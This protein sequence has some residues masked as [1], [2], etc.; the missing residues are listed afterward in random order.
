MPW[1]F[2]KKTEEKPKPRKKR[3]FAGG[4]FGRLLNDWIA[5]ST[6][7]DSEISTSLPALRNRARQL[8]RDN[9]F[10]KAA[11]RAVQVNVVGTGME[12]QAQIKMMR[13]GG[14]N[15]DLNEKIEAIWKSWS[16]A[17]NC[18]VSGKLALNE[19]CSMVV[20]SLVDSG[21]ILIRMV[22]KQFGKSR[23]P[24]G[25]EIIEADQLDE[26]R[27]GK[28][29][30]N[31]IRMGVEV[32][33]WHRPVNYW[34]TQTHP[35]DN[36]TGVGGKKE[37]VPIP[38]SQ[39]LHLFVSDRPGQTRGYPMMH[40]SIKRLHH[41]SGF[42]EAE[43]IYNRSA[44]S[45]MGFLETP[46]GEVY[47]DDVVDDERVMDFAPGMIRGLAPG[48]RFVGF[49]PN[50]P[51]GNYEPFVRA[52][53]RAIA[54]GIGCSYETIS[55]DFSQTNYSS[56]RLSLLE[57]RE[58]WKVLQK[59]IIQKFLQPVYEKWLEQAVLSGALQLD[60]YSAMPE[61]YHQVRWQTRG[62]SWVDPLKEVK[63]YQEAVRNGFL[64]V[65]DVVAQTGG[66]IEDLIRA[67]ERELKLMEESGLT[68][69][70][71]PAQV[72]SVSQRW[73]DDLIKR[74]LSEDD[75]EIQGRRNQSDTD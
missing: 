41:L 37:S 49:N 12:L 72:G 29:N 7:I 30:G 6:N 65:T 17:G 51:S 43:V 26:T 61:H 13:G 34:I 58:N 20:G 31:T 47:S 28:H 18:H 56:S 2:K 38:A 50:K 22:P 21:E 11:K 16:Q 60:G 8:V 62:W 45:M 19:I 66:D 1:P 40:S 36:V 54:A 44:A 27:N 48:E 15:D 52:M 3:N 33:E 57:D 75:G 32:D 39:I 35:G 24:L 68:Y 5:A 69:D 9:D 4:Q 70:S 10:A 14:M 55:R 64:T 73:E 25:L 74:A 71:N 63:A 42:E 46:E 67:R 59:W 23:V 53:I